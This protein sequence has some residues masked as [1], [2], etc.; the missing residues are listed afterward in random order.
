MNPAASAASHC[1]SKKSL[2]L[3][4]PI[5]LFLSLLALLSFF[6]WLPTFGTM[7]SARADSLHADPPCVVPAQIMARVELFFGSGS[8]V[9][10]RTFAAFLAREVTPRFP[11]GLSLFEGYGQWRD[12]AARI[13]RERSR[14]LLIYYRFDAASSDKIEAIRLAYKKRFRQKSVLRADSSACVAF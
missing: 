2:R 10:P 5:R 3:R 1:L 13:S 8:G 4:R 11:D 9:T 12:G 14:L 6:L 7:R